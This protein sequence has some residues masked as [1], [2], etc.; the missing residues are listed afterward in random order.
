M[1]LAKIFGPEKVEAN[2]HSILSQIRSDMLVSSLEKY[3]G[4]LLERLQL[5]CGPPRQSSV[6]QI[7]QFALYR[8]SNNL[9]SESSTDELLRWLIEQQKIE[10]LTSFL[11]IKMPTVHAC[12]TKILESAL[13][14]QD[15]N[16]LQL[17]IDSGVDLSPLKGVYGSGYLV[18]AA[19]EGD[20]QTA[21][22]LLKNG[23][24]VNIPSDD[25]LIALQAAAF[26]GHANLVQVFLKAG[27]NVDAVSP[28]EEC[29]TALSQ[30]VENDD[31]ELVR[32]LLTAGANIDSCK[33]LNSPAIEH[34][35]IYTD[36]DELHYLLLSAS[37][38]GYSSITVHG[39]S[40]AASKGTQALSKYLAEKGGSRSLVRK[41][42]KNALKSACRNDHSAAI[43]ILDIGVDLDYLLPCNLGGPLIE[44][45]RQENFELIKTLLRAGADINTPHILDSTIECDKG[46]DSVINMLQFM[47]EEGA[48]IKTQGK[49]ALKS[50]AYHGNLEVVQY[51]I[52]AGVDVNA[53]TNG[54]TDRTILQNA[55]LSRNIGLVKILLKAGSD[56]NATCRMREETALETAVRFVAKSGPER[57][58]IVQVLLAAGADVNPPK[59]NRLLQSAIFNGDEELAC[60]LLDKGADVNSFPKGREGRSPV[61]DA[62]ERGNLSFVK[63]LLKSGAN[64]N[65]SPSYYHGRTAIQAASSAFSPTMELIDFLLDTGAEMNAPPAFYGGVTA[66]Q[67]AAIRGHMKIALKFLEAGADVN[68][69]AATVNGRTALDGA[70][71]HGRL[72][73]VQMLLNAGACGDSSKVHRFDEAIELA[74]KNGH[75]AVANLLESA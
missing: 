6:L 35:A 20:M 40:E 49:G 39:V 73:M 55:V 21:Q 51:L 67:G 59:G 3:D 71:E 8:L 52:S 2:G 54:F 30:A 32:I 26:N 14:I 33:I 16:F 27:A 15:A 63:L 34:S 23:A 66:L 65:A 42:L 43:P 25:D 7:L 50:A 75:F 9:L 11:K 61:Q 48:D 53:Q 18:S 36:N 4:E 44:A 46:D 60:I 12:A 64:I 56:V 47:L 45:V 69:A 13:R 62:A 17:L 24:D 41:V 57:L 5:F 72:D 38:K 19:Y 74:Q 28:Y 58:E 22:I 31:I 70:A 29:Y 10:L 37:S 1:L 68:A